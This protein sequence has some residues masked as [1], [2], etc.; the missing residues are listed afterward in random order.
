MKDPI[1]ERF[2]FDGQDFQPFSETQWYLLV[3]VPGEGLTDQ[4]AEARVTRLGFY[5]V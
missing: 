4:P 1:M 5:P 3:I 2:N